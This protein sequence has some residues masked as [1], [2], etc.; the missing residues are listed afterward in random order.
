MTDG[1]RRVIIENLT[2]QVPGGRFP[3]KRAVGEQ[4]TVTADIFVDGHDA[5]CAVMRYRLAGDV[6]E[7]K[8]YMVHQANDRWTASVRIAEPCDIYFTVEA[9]VDHFSSWLE[10]AQKKHAADQE[11]TVELMDAANLLRDAAQRAANKDQAEDAALLVKFAGQLT[12]L[13]TGKAMVLANKPILAALSNKHADPELVTRHPEDLHIRVEPRL[14]AFSAW[15]ELFPRSTAPGSRHGTFRSVIDQLP[16]ISEM[17][18]DI[19]YLPPIHPVGETYR[20]G[21]NNNPEALPDDVGSPWAIGS[22]AGG[23]TAVHPELGTIEEFTGLVDAA[24][25]MGL[26]VALDMAFQ[27]SPDH[28]WVSEHPEW[29]RLRADGTIQYAENPPKKYQDI[30]PFDFEC[31]DWQNLWNALRDVFLFWVERG[32]KVFRV[33]NPHTK[34]FSFWAWCLEEVRRSH[35]DVIFLAEAFSRPKV[36]YRLAKAGFTQSYTYFTWRNS[37]HELTQY[38]TELARTAPRDFFRPNFWPNT[39]DILPEYLQYGGRPDVYRPTGAGSD[40]F[41]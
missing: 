40:A 28:P 23:H 10:R 21:R 19:L 25:E 33:D 36:M 6:A 31:A 8:L 30:Y 18:F 9:W 14:A 35:P 2:P 32:V 7:Q 20:K 22:A 27:C 37:K 11:M 17:G 34:P 38:V 26:A 16:R 12:G 39:P 13:P 1:R 5:L 24:R 3:A 29:F 15:Y 41:F 4:L